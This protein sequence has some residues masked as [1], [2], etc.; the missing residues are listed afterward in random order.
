MAQSGTYLYLMQHVDIVDHISKKG[1]NLE[2]IKEYKDIHRKW[3]AIESSW[4]Q[5]FQISESFS[6][7]TEWMRDKHGMAPVLELGES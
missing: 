7:F 5:N 6:Y 3:N 1:R 2:Q 4:P